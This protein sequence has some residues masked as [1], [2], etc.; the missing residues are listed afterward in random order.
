MAGSRTGTPSIIRYSRKICKLKA[1]W[2]AAN[3][4]SATSPEF[5][6]A[7][8]ALTIACA[9]FEALDNYPAQ[10]DRIAPDGPEDT[11]DL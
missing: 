2:G 3:L 11:D 5:A 4:S 8:T 10:I 6:A 1:Q 7:V 9:A